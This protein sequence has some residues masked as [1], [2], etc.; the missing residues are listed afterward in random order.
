MDGW[1]NKKVYIET[2]SGRKYSGLVIAESN[3]KLIIIDIKQHIV[4]L[5]KMDIKLCQEED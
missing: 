4:E 1:K 2:F 3:V 5:S